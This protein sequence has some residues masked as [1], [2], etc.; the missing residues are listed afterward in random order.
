MGF[1]ELRANRAGLISDADRFFVAP[2][3]ARRQLGHR[4]ARRGTYRPDGNPSN[5]RRSDE[6]KNTRDRS[7]APRPSPSHSPTTRI[8]PPRSHAARRTG[9]DESL[10]LARGKKNSDA[11][12]PQRGDLAL[13]LASIAV[14]ICLAYTT[15]SI[16]LV[17]AVITSID[18]SHRRQSHAWVAETVY[19]PRHMSLPVAR[20]SPRSVTVT[21]AP[22]E[23]QLAPKVWSGARADLIHEAETIPRVKPSQV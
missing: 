7:T 20:V 1:I 8:R 4:Y 10:T 16:C 14:K 11:L 15:A 2:R 13:I 18:R 3:A 6:K 9:P 19:R 23:A 5:F 12:G 17:T 21:S 22:V